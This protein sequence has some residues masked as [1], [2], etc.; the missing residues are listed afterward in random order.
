MIEQGVTERNEFIKGSINSTHARYPPEKEL[1]E[2]RSAK[3]DEKS[4]LS[5]SEFQENK[6]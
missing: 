1:S 4:P 6:D 3:K 5:K 2:G